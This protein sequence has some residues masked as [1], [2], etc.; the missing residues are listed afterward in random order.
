MLAVEIHPAIVFALSSLL[1]AGIND[2]VFKR[3]SRKERSRG[4]YVF[5]I[6]VVWTVLQVIVFRAQGTALTFDHNTLLFGLTAGVFLTISNILLIESLTHIDVSLGSTIYRLN[7]IGV[8]ILSVVF[9]SEPLGLLKSL[10]IVAGISGVLLLYHKQSGSQTNT[11]FAV[12]FAVAI[13]ASLFRAAY[14]VTAKAGLLQDADPNAMLLLFSSSWIV[15]GAC[16]AKL[17]E[18]RFQLTRKKVLYSLL[19]GI[20]VFLIVNFLMLAIERGEASIAIPVANLSFV[21]AL[22]LSIVLK[23]ESLTIRKLSAVGCA[24][25]SIVLLSQA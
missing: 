23:M 2:V 25:L 15:G 6:G 12:F 20:L 9:L 16:Y 5:G 19:S 18:K 17:R 3:Y 10:G 4:V 21:I 22:F 13:V 8:V 7:T 14:G 24:V 11:V 1:F